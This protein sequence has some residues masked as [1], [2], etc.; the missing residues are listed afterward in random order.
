MKAPS[1]T[2][3]VYYRLHL[4][5]KT[6]ILDIPWGSKAQRG[7]RIMLLVI[8]PS[9]TLRLIS[10]ASGWILVYISMTCITPC[11]SVSVTLTHTHTH[12]EINNKQ[13]THARIALAQI[14]SIRGNRRY[15]RFEALC[16][17]VKLHLSF[18][19]KGK[20]LW[21]LQSQALCI[22]WCSC[23]EAPNML[24]CIQ[25]CIQ[26]PSA[27]H[28]SPQTDH[29]GR[30]NCLKFNKAVVKSVELFYETYTDEEG[31]R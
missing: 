3:C 21:L 13:W 7:E 25:Q 9:V 19:T 5:K 18:F 2:I 4:L 14:V 28:L 6:G 23:L 10:A 26:I 16:E 24:E 11:F 17:T 12:T 31:L 20:M 30:R 8:L 29:C 22:L 15:L 1:K 27:P